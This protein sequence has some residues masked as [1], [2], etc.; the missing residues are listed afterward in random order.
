MYKGEECKSKKYPYPNTQGW[1]RKAG[2]ERRL[3]KSKKSR[4]EAAK[5]GMKE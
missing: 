4:C 5:R 2:I 1:G 3:E